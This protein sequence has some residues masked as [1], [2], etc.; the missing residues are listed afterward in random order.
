MPPNQEA[1][2]MSCA[3]NE[4]VEY[5]VEPGKFKWKYGDTEIEY[6]YSYDKPIDG[7][8]SYSVWAEAGGDLIEFVPQQLAHLGI[9]AE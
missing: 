5:E 4:G 9:E 2:D 8:D 6:E 3:I 7:G 1:L